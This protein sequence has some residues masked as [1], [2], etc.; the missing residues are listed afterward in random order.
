[1]KNKK[2]LIWKFKI[3]EKDQKIK[4]EKVGEPVELKLQDAEVLFQKSTVNI[5]LL[6]FGVLNGILPEQY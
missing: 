5:N 2:I 1:M 6:R 3:T 4:L